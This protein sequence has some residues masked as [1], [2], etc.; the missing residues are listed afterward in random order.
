MGIARVSTLC[1]GSYTYCII[2][3]TEKKTKKR[4]AAAS[5]KK[6][7]STVLVVGRANNCKAEAG[8]DSE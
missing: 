4:A 6:S 3:R 8:L 5:L 2:L 7:L 1:K